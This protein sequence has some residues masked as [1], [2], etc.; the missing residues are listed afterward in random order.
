MTTEFTKTHHGHMYGVPVWLDMTD[1]ECPGVEPKYGLLGECAWQVLHFLFG[2]FT[3]TV[4]TLN[5]D[6]DPEFPIRVGAPV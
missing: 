4:S 6:Y 1:P 2:C 5:P 3:W